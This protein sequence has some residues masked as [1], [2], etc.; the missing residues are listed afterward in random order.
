MRACLPP[1]SGRLVRVLAAAVAWCVAPI[2]PMHAQ[3]GD[4]RGAVSDS[5]SGAP[6]AGAVVLLLD[7]AGATIGR[8]ITGARGTYRLSRPDAAE[9]VRT[10][11]LGF[12]PATE[13]LP[14]LRAPL[15]IMNL[16][17]SPVPRGLDAVEVVVAQ[18]CPVR[19]DRAE[20]FALLDQARAGLL[21]TIVAR[22]REP[23]ALTILR[24]E[25]YLD[26]DGIDVEKQYVRVDSARSATTSFNAVQ[27]AVDFV[28]RGFRS[29]SAGQFVYYGPDADVLLD[30]RFLRGYCF[31]VAAAD[32]A[33]VSQIGLHF[34]AASRRAG[35]VDIDGTL[36]ID[37]AAKSMHD[38]TFRY[39]G[40]EPLAESFRVGGRVGFRT[41]PSGVPFID[42]WSLRLVGAPDT[43][44]SD[45]ARTSQVYAVREVGGELAE[46][47]WADG[48]RWTGE[49]GDVHLTA[50]NGT[51]APLRGATLRLLDSDYRVTVDDDGRGTIAHVLPGRYTLVADD[52]ALATVALPIPTGRAVTVRRAQSAL[53]R[54]T[55][56]TAVTH[57][58][59]LCRSA[60]PGPT[61]TESWVIGRVIGN[62][63]QPAAGAHW[64]ISVADG[65]RWRVIADNGLT[66]S[67]G[68]IMLCRGVVR[69]ASVEVAAWRDPKD[70]VRVRRVLEG[71]LSA[72]RIPLPAVVVTNGRAPGGN[73]A[74]AMVRGVV[75]DSLTGA[76]VADARVTLLG[77]PFEGATDSSG[78]FAI[79]GVW[80]GEYVVEVSTPALD[81]IGAVSRTRLV[82]DGASSLVA[83]FTPSIPSV[84]G[85]SCGAPDIPGAIAGRVAW[86]GPLP[87]GMRV[88]AEWPLDADSAGG[89]V[90]GR[91]A[92]AEAPV[93]E[94]GQFRICRVPLGVPL[95]LR[96]EAERASS[97]GARALRIQLTADR[98]IARAD[99]ML[100]STVVATASLTGSVLTDTA[101]TPLNNAEVTI[102]DLRRSVTTDRRGR[103]RLSEIPSGEH[104][105]SIRHVGYAPFITAMVFEPNRAVEQRILLNRAPTL[106]SVSVIADARADGLPADFDERRRAGMG[107]FLA[108]TELDRHAGRRL[109]DVLTQVA[110]F[111]AAQG[112]GSHAWVVG[113]RAPSHLLPNATPT[114]AAGERAIGCGTTGAPGR[115][116][117]P[118]CTFSMSD[119]R[120]QGYYCPSDAE[121]R[122]GIPSC[123]C[124]SQ[125]YLD[126]R[127]LNTGRPTEPFD[128]NT[129]PVDDIA[130][131]EFY[132]TAA[133]TPGRYSALNAV[134]GVMLVWTR[135]R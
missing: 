3:A 132:A 48:Q 72:F 112:S 1:T 59:T 121:R 96:A 50:V 14:S 47:R 51:G 90:G 81:S 22:E 70:A 35:R 118:I 106:A 84:M 19:S 8:T 116:Q 127:L 71:E 80:R 126:G 75:R 32:S 38:I 9:L 29:G 62:D 54:V 110:G 24:F 85:L 122:Q 93:D 105:V 95:L 73:R 79:G 120:E 128:A 28:D 31:S 53:L 34:T 111:G 13:R 61:A 57:V 65:A 69:N 49:L 6:I 11:R 7:A 30:E 64:R 115:G 18:G 98:R 130:G 37:T 78:V 100:D 17:M 33:R 135:R 46:A 123:A 42:Q 16:V 15:M 67:D 117:A 23:A 109:G 113:K 86:Q 27:N 77:S 66:G 108:R 74:T 134:C 21:A 63:G 82:V 91:M 44:R 133:G 107:R 43:S 102:T 45:L 26:L 2:A 114:P 104:L 87:E 119:L 58:G 99:L 101:G 103:F 20:A 83:L 94:R 5:A 88:V 52:T 4:L 92:W 55:V 41:L 68:L 39:I 76:V 97:A 25:R 56:P 10:V 60:T 12:R 36:W 89:A 131:V 40:V 125:V 124:F 129:L